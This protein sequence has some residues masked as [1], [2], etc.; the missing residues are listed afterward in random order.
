MPR[1]RSVKEKARYK[2]EEKTRRC[3]RN[4]ENSIQDFKYLF[5]IFKN[6]WRISLFDM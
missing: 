6:K 4:I 3:K 2:M 5:K 1:I